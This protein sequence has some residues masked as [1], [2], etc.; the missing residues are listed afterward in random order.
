MLLINDE[1]RIVFENENTKLCSL[2]KYSKG[3][4]MF[5]VVHSSG[6]TIGNSYNFENII[7][8]Q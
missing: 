1:L 4:N 5:A 3:G 2:I 7:N 8:I 6:I